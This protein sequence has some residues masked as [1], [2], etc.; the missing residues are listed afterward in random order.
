M[1]ETN[2]KKSNGGEKSVDN[3]KQNDNKKTTPTKPDDET[4]L[5]PMVKKFGRLFGCMLFGYMVGYTNMST[6][7]LSVA[8]FMWIV[9]DKNRL[10]QQRRLEF[11][12]AVADDEK[13][14]VKY[15]VQDLP[16]WVI[17]PDTER[18][19]WINRIFKQMW[20]F[21]G[22]YVKNLLKNKVEQNIDQLSESHRPIAD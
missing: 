11:E 14:M 18:A 8:A 3:K 22:E 4:D 9:R 12:R 19:E 10:L 5:I 20:P 13:N 21:L 1:G 6:W 15:A 2:N 16:C 17:F 7:W